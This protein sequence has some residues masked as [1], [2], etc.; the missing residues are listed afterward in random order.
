[1]SSKR[2]TKEFAEMSQN[3]PPDFSVS[4]P[5]SQSIHSWHVVLSAPAG[6][7]YHPG[8]FALLLTLPTD[9]PFKPPS[10]RFLTRIYHPNVTDDSLGNICLAILK[11]DQ[12]KPSTK[13]A[14]V[15]DAVRNLL[16]EPQPDD[17]LEERIADEYRTDKVAWEKKAQ[18]HVQKYATGNPVFPAA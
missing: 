3:P 6:T 14:A 1:M 12:W 2:I 15:L 17:P 16:V 11:S 10:L 5:A 7:P 13:I 8:R 18:Q 9:Y 4:L